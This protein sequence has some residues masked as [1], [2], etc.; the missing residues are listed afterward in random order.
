KDA[1][2]VTGYEFF[3]NYHL[4]GSMQLDKGEAGIVF[5]YR[6]EESAAEENAEKPANEDF[7]ALTLLLTGTQPD[8]REIRLWHSRQGQ[9]TY[10]ARAQT[11]LYQRQWY[12][13][14]LKVVDDQII[15]YLDGY[16]VFRVKNSLPPGGKIGFYANTDNEIRFDDVA[17]RSINHIDLATVGDIRFQAWKHSGGF[18]QRPGI[19]FPGTPDDQTLLLAQAKRQPEY[20]IL[21]RPHN[22]TGVFSF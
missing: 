13:P 6:S 20:L 18:Y 1:V 3:G 14:G 11:P 12:Q 17:L 4:T 2:I 16:E 19:L 15:A 22:H 8:Q 21:G 9:R 5:F 7:Y 10:L